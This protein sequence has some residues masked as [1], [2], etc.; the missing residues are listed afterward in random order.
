MFTKSYCN[1]TLILPPSVSTSLP[2]L[3]RYYH[4]MTG[5]SKEAQ[6]NNPVFRGT[7]LPFSDQYDSLNMDISVITAEINETLDIAL[8][9]DDEDCTAQPYYIC[10]MEEPSGSGEIFRNFFSGSG[11]GSGSGSSRYIDDG[12]RDME[13]GDASQSDID[14]ETPAI[15]DPSVTNPTPDNSGSG[16]NA[17]NHD[18]PTNEGYTVIDIT[19]SGS[20]GNAST[21]GDNTTNDTLTP[22]VTPP[23]ITVDVEDDGDNDNKI[24]GGGVASLHQNTLKAAVSFSA[25][26]LLFALV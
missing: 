6:V 20:G 14:E 4:A 18:E 22:Q 16:M 10:D 11:S 1:L 21:T 7:I 19:N 3:S 24:V 25:S 5:A 2:H 26:L 15:S 17:T 8:C 9:L 12:M 23:G 13:D